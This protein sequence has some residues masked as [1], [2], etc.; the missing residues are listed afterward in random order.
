MDRMPVRNKL[1]GSSLTL[2]L[3]IVLFPAI[4]RASSENR[5]LRI[6]LQRYFQG[7]R[8]ASLLSS[9]DFVLI[10]S[11]TGA[12]I[13][14]STNLEP[15]TLEAGKSSLVLKRANG[16]QAE[17]GRSVIVRSNAEDALITVESPGRQCKKYRGA[18][19]VNLVSGALQLINVIDLEDYLLGV[20]PPEMPSMYPAEALKAQ[21]VAA[22]TYALENRRKH[23]GSGYELCDSTHCQVYDGAL[24]EKPNCTRAVLDT[25]GVVITYGGELASIMYSADCGGATRAYSNV[26]KFP[27]LCG[28]KEPE[29]VEHTAWKA[30]FKIADVRAKLVKAGIKEAAGLTAITIATTDSSGRVASLSITSPTG[31]TTITGDK[32][33]A[34]L[35]SSIQSL[36]FGIEAGADGTITISGKGCGHGVGMCQV[37]AK[38]LAQSPLNYTYDRILAH[39]FPGTTLTGANITPPTIAAKAS[40]PANTDAASLPNPKAHSSAANSGSGRIEPPPQ[41][42][43]IFDVRV[44]APEL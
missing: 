11:K 42:G 2:A 10:D 26:A 25:S 7:I 40:P 30:C 27:Y 21:A 29:H 41:C 22:R 18:L 17:V 33:K 28:V 39:Y 31:T 34:A 19:E 43:L 20:V 3:L 13:A 36:M 38:G 16:K 9:S 1:L 14:S 8:Q 37:G 5:Q 4:T 23:A 12:A 32:L 44:K 35:G 15:I 6:G 24:A